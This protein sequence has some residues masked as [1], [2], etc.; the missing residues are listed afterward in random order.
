MAD[1]PGKTLLT[2]DDILQEDL[3][4]ILVRAAGEAADLPRTRIAQAIRAAEDFYERDLQ[5]FFGVQ[6]VASDPVERGL[7]PS[8]YDRAEPAYDYEPELWDGRRWGRIDLNYRPVVSIDQVF[9]SYPGT[10]FAKMFQIPASWIRLDR[11]YGNFKIVPASGAALM[12]LNGYLLS[13]FAGGRGVPRS[14]FIDYQTGIDPDTMADEHADLLEGLRYR[15]VLNLMGV[16]NVVRSSGVGSHSISQDGQSQSE[17]FQ[18]GKWGA[19]SGTVEMYQA[20]EKDI[21]NNWRQ[22]EHG[23]PLVVC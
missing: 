19:Y 23:V 18:S 1:A 17:S 6:R 3:Y 11:K 2:V 4:G 22:Q 9:F 12:G 7:D 13:V 10:G 14:I 21:R 5:V 16:L 15:T 20:Q 8:T